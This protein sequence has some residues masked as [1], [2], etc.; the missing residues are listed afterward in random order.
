MSSSQ[1][2]SRSVGVA[3][4]T[5]GRKGRRVRE[6][7]GKKRKEEEMTMKDE[8]EVGRQVGTTKQSEKGGW[9]GYQHTDQPTQP[10]RNERKQTSAG[11]V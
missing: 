9:A 1:C 3:A 4:T 6:E 7:R 2:R 8:D 5:G 10:A 11:I